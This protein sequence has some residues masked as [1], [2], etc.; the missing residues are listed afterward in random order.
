MSRCRAKVFVGHLTSPNV[1]VSVRAGITV[2]DDSVVLGGVTA[3]FYEVDRERCRRVGSQT[4]LDYHGGRR[5][6][7]GS[8]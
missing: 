1:C 8:V 7:R 4:G 3:A 5:D 6:E 2:C